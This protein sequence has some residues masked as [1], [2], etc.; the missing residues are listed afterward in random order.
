MTGIAYY[1]NFIEIFGDS[2][3]TEV[4]PEL[5][6]LLPDPNKRSELMAIHQKE[7]AKVW[8]AFKACAKCLQAAAFPKL[9]PNKHPQLHTPAP[10]PAPAPPV[11]AWK[12]FNPQPSDWVCFNVF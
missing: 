7:I 2:K 10:A 4:F 1:S 5:T 8:I 12:A 11:E 3:A 6:A 9:K